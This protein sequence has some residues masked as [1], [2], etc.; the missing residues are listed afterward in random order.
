[1][2]KFGVKFVALFT[3]CLTLFAIL[4]PFNATLLFTRTLS[5][6]RSVNHFKPLLDVYQAPYKMKCYYWV[7][8]HLLIKALFYALSALEKSTNLTIGII[9]LHALASGTYWVCASF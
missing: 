2:L 9:V 8:L 5:R 6:H 3:V 7:G 4:L 1:M